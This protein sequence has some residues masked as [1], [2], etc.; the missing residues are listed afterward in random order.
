[1][2]PRTY[3]S[4]RKSG[5]VYSRVASTTSLMTLPSWTIRDG[6]GEDQVCASANKMGG[7]FASVGGGSVGRSSL[8]EERRDGQWVVA[9]GVVVVMK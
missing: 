9:V 2:R 7:R 8:A 5:V 3:Y 4:F 1:M 6:K